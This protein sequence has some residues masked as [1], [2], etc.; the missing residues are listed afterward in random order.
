MMMRNDGYYECGVFDARDLPPRRTVIAD[1]I[2]ALA[3]GQHFDHPALAQAG[4]WRPPLYKE[5]DMPAIQ[6]IGFDRDLS[7]LA[8]C[9]SRRRLPTQTSQRRSQLG[10]PWAQ[11]SVTEAG[12]RKTFH[13]RYANGDGLKLE[14]WDGFDKVA[15][16]NAFLD[17]LIDGLT[18]NCELVGARGDNQYQVQECPPTA[19]AGA[20]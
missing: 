10:G 8:E 19:V 18:G 4:W 11:I 9:C 20:L 14:I 2:A 6:I 12:D 1:A 13:A 5:H 7:V 15:A 16:C 17:L 3:T